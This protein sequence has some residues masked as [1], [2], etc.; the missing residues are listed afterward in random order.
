MRFRQQQASIPT[1][2]LIP[3]LNVLLGVLAF[4][5]IITMTLGQPRGITIQLPADAD[6]PPEE[7]DEPGED[8]I[9]PL[10]IRLGDAGEYF[11]DD[12]PIPYEGINPVMQEHLAQ[13]DDTLVFLVADKQVPYED[14]IDFLVEMKILGGDRVSLALE[15]S[16]S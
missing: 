6:A 8:P 4:F 1:I 7:L 3:M 14:V 5:V 15:E 2:N 11:I 12:V 13:R 9:P 16:G 10:I